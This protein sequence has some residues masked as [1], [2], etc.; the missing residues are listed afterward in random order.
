MKH[1]FPKW[2]GLLVVAAVGLYVLG[3]YSSSGAAPQG[4]Q[5]PFANPI[6]QRNEMIRELR[7]IKELLKEQNSLLRG[8]TKTNATAAPQR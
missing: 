7:E 2:S 1:Q 5:P 8:T 6:D 4:G 3:F